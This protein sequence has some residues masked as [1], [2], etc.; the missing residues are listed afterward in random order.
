M[1]SFAESFAKLLKIAEAFR[2]KT[3]PDQIRMMHTGIDSRIYAAFSQIDR[4][5]FVGPFIQTVSQYVPYATREQID[6]LIYC[7]GI[8]LPIEAQLNTSQPLLMAEMY[9]NGLPV[10]ACTKALEIGA[11][12]GYGTALLSKFYDHVYGV[13]IDKNLARQANA[14]LK[15]AN[16]GNADIIHDNGFKWMKKNVIKLGPFDTI[17]V[18]A[19]FPEDVYS[20]LVPYLSIGGRLVMPTITSKL[21]RCTRKDEKNIMWEEIRSDVDFVNGKMK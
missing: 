2:G 3:L 1:G 8:A 4:K 21:I 9:Q 16:I 7:C 14:N 6:S 5:L 17:I 11:G 10:G 12:C 20:K 13:E 19:A 15:A 18:S